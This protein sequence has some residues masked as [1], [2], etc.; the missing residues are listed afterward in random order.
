[1]HG[2]G[3]VHF[4]G[5]IAVVTDGGRV[6]TTDTTLTV[7][8][9]NEALVF[10]NFRTDYQRPAFIQQLD[11]ELAAASARSYTTLRDRHVAD[12]SPLFARV[13]LQLGNRNPQ[14]GTGKSTANPADKP[15]DERRLAAL[16]GADDPDLDALF[17]QMGRYLT[18]ASSRE[19]SPLPIALQGFFNDNL[20]CHMGWTNDYHLDINTQQNY[21][22]ANVGNL[23]ECNAP[24]FRWIADLVEPGTKTAQTVYG[25]KGWTAHTTVNV[26]GYTAPSSCI[27]WGLHPTAA[28]WIAAHL[29]TNYE[30]T[31][32]QDY[33]RRVA[34]PLL[35]GNAEFLLDFMTTDPR[36]G[37]L[38]TGPSI[39]PENAFAVDGQQF[40]ASLMPTCDR[41][42]AWEV[43]NA[44]LQ[45]ARILHLD[46]PLQ[47][48]L[49][50]ALRHLPAYKIGRDGGIQEWAEDYDQPNP[51]HRHTCH[52]MGFWPYAQITLQHDPVLATAVRRTFDLRLSAA[53]WEDVEW[54]RANAIGVY[55][56]LSDAEEAYRSVKMLE[57][58]LSRGNLLTVSPAG[59]AGAE[60]DIFAIDGNTA[61]TAGIAEMLLQT[62]NG[63]LQ[64]LPA[65]PAAWS[66]GSFSGLCIRGGA[67]VACAWADGHITRATLTATTDGTFAIEVPRYGAY[68]ATAHGQLLQPQNGIW[69]VTL[70]KGESVVIQ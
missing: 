64:L 59:I 45:S 65:L 1:M 61:G 34:Y 50:D 20:A 25:C 33:L 16:N 46:A 3:G 12:Y 5:R 24:L 4:A 13:T 53:G 67:E 66:H 47:A 62:Q 56:R 58:Y 35:R 32:D 11:Q 69:Q 70:R 21:W 15:T 52:I 43:L 48:R 18:I 36:T 37:T 54:S 9:A 27:A 42:F 17:F 68:A 10:I 8:G 19:N 7:T 14:P 41:T 39:S 40:C 29:W 31:Q 26:W 44:T 23:A 30:Y 60:D 57:G 55:A 49:E 38:V 22:A 2:P 63:Y 51:N 6:N 28:S